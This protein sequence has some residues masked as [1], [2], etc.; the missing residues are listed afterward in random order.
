MVVR[1]IRR[2]RPTHTG[3]GLSAQR[4]RLL[5]LGPSLTFHRARPLSGWASLRR[6]NHAMR[7]VG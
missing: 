5:G 4:D 2:H 3:I 7:S 6:R 1:A